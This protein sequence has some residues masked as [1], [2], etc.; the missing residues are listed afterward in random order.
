MSCGLGNFN[1]GKKKRNT[2]LLKE[3]NSYPKKFEASENK[4]K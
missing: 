4:V 1:C 2:N 3:I